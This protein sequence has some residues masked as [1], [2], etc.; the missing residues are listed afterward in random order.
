MHN[1]PSFNDIDVVIVVVFSVRRSLLP[2]FSFFFGTPSF[3]SLEFFIPPL[4]LSLSLSLCG[5]LFYCVYVC[6]VCPQ[7]LSQSCLAA[8]NVVLAAAGFVVILFLYYLP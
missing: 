4:D 2:L 8:I 1:R 3:F 5:V 7:F 6:I